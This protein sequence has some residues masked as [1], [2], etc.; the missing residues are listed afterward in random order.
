MTFKDKIKGYLKSKREQIQRGRI[1]TEQ[2][3][4]DRLR[5][6]TNKLADMKPGALKTIVV[7]LKTKANPMDLMKE[8]YARRKYERGE[9]YERR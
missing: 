1:V 7:G 6:R 5:K 9:K 4:A 3:R 8:E 2:M